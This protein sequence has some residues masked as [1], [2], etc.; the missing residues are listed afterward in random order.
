MNFV[1]NDPSWWSYLDALFFVAYWTS[2]VYQ[3]VMTRSNIN[4]LFQ[5]PLASWWYMTGIELIWVSDEVSS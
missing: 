4:L 3:S 2:L 1:S 5:L